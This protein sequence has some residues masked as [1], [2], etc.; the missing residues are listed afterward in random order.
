MN[1]VPGGEFSPMIH[2]N[3]AS[4]AGGYTV[5]T[6]AFFHYVLRLCE[7]DMP[8]SRDDREALDVLAAI[9]HAF[10]RDDE[11]SPLSG[12]GWRIVPP[13]DDL[14]W[15]VLEATPQRLRSALE[16][17]RTILWTRAA[18]FRIS[19][20][21]IASIEHELDAVDGVILRAEV[22][23]VPISVSYVA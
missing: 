9:P 21:D 2:V 16:R 23:G 8:L 4:S 19:A 11:S 1:M 15:P 18:E 5:G 7:L 3:V 17:A 22:A 13:R 12:R 10:E 20:Q 14:D 6:P